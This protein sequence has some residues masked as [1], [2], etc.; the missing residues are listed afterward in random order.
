MVGEMAS[1]ALTHLASRDALGQPASQLT[2]LPA[3][4]ASRDAHNQISS[5]LPLWLT[6]R[7]RMR[8]ALGRRLAACGPETARGQSR[9]AARDAE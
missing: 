1:E 5:E 7:R 8:L 6:F 9:R 2:H 3:K 4:Q